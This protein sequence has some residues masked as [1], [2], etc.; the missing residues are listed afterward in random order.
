MRMTHRDDGK[1]GFV[2]SIR[3]TKHAN[4]YTRQQ[5]DWNTSFS[6]SFVTHRIVKHEPLVHGSA[7][8]AN[9]PIEIARRNLNYMKLT[10]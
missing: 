5:T 9:M 7:Q 1:L 6:M 8:S 10:I 3:V 4:T 2:M